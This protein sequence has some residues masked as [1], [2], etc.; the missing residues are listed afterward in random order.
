VEIEG[1]RSQDASYR[2]GQWLRLRL[3]HLVVIVFGADETRAS[4]RSACKGGARPE[5]H[6]PPGDLKAMTVPTFL[7]DRAWHDRR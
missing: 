1:R 2:L 3:G 4:K 6:P 7:P 5:H